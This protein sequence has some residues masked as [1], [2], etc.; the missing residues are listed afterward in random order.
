MPG[1]VRALRRRGRVR[2]GAENFVR[3]PASRGASSHGSCSRWR[4]RSARAEAAAR[5]RCSPERPLC[6]LRAMR[7]T[8]AATIR[9]SSPPRRSSQRRIRA[10][11]AESRNRS[12]PTSTSTTRGRRLRRTQVA[13]A[14]ERCPR[15][16]YDKALSA[17]SRENSGGRLAGRDRSASFSRP[18]RLLGRGAGPWPGLGR[19]Q[20]RLFTGS[21][22]LAHAFLWRL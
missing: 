12:L 11:L 22:S 16:S 4:R 5:S 9:A 19:A 6:R 14:G 13:C 10:S 3:K 20:A 15:V 21:R 18:Q 17:P 8:S 2:G 1:Y 7:A